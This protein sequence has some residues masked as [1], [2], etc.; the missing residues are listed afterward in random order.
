[1]RT[2]HAILIAILGCGALV[3]VAQAGDSKVTHWNSVAPQAEETPSLAA[4]HPNRNANETPWRDM[5]NATPVADPD[6]I[7]RERPMDHANPWQKGV[8]HPSVPTMTHAAVDQKF[9]L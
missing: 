5:T 4:L 2:K 3:G 8:I 6:N 7:H 1:M 9:N